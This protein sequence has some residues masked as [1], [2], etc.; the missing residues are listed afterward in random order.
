MMDSGEDTF[1]NADFMPRSLLVLG[2]SGKIHR[3]KKAHAKYFL[4]GKRQ[5]FR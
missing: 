1:I 5:N 2:V 3:T 4:S